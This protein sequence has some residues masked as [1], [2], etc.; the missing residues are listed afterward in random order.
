MLSGMGDWEI[1]NGAEIFR[2]TTFD[3]QRGGK[4]NT[5]FLLDLPQT[6]STLHELEDIATSIYH[7]SWTGWCALS[8]HLHKG[9]EVTPYTVFVLDHL[10]VFYTHVLSQYMVGFRIFLWKSWCMCSVYH[11]FLLPSSKGLGTR[12]ACLWLMS[13]F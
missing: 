3:R 13:C 6:E 5:M 12:L 4:T 7:G 9:W 1:E 2:H 11:P 10:S 8:G